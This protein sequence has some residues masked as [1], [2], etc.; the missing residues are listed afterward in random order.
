MNVK[1][2]FAWLVGTAIRFWL[3]MLL[4]SVLLILMLALSGIDT[5]Q[6]AQSELTGLEALL[7][8]ASFGASVLI[9][10]KWFKKKKPKTKSE[11]PV[12]T[13]LE[14]KPEP[15]P[16]APINSGPSREE[17]LMISSKKLFQ[18]WKNAALD[19]Q[20]GDQKKKVKRIEGDLSK[21]NDSFN[22]LLRRHPNIKKLSPKSKEISKAGTDFKRLQE[23]LSQ[24]ED[25]TKS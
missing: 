3:F 18:T 9:W 22:D 24:L 25:V 17:K 19:I 5:E 21:L 13:T 14:A 12:S 15:A 4:W 23:V 7:F 20:E 6:S 16:A 2:R 10:R 1:A 8:F 11:K